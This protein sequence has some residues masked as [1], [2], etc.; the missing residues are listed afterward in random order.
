MTM[1][2]LEL[3]YSNADVERFDLVVCAIGYESRARFAA[4]TLRLCG[5]KNLAYAFRDRSVHSFASNLDWFKAAKFDCMS[6][7]DAGFAEAL[8]L[9]LIDGEL[10]GEELERAAALRREK[11]GSDEWTR[12]L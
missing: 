2:H 11:Y 5:K 8:K 4:E 1:I 12:K 6:V 10:T 9:T 3:T 7:D